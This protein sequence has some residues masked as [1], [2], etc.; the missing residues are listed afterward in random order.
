MLV[1]VSV[2]IPVY[3]ENIN[4]SAAIGVEWRFVH[5][6]CITKNMNRLAGIRVEWRFVHKV[7]INKQIYIYIYVYM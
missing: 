3:I 4:C 6:V 7:G 1:Y 2:Y 5:K